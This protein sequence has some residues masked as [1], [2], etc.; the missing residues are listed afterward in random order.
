MVVHYPIEVGPFSRGYHTITEDVFKA[1]GSLPESGMLFIFIQHTSAGLTIN[2][3]ADPD[4]LHDF[5]LYIDKLVPENMPGVRHDIEGPDDMPAHIKTT[6][7]DTSLAIPIMNGR[8]QLGQWQG[9]WLCEFRNHP[10]KRSLII[11]VVS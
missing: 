10:R 2:E 4:V 8:L 11:S 3:S 6:L 1:L 9:I 7:T 5:A